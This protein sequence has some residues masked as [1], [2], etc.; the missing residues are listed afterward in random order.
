MAAVIIL[1]ALAGW[2]TARYQRARNDHTGAKAAVQTTRRI[3]GIE[4]RG[5]LLIAAIVFLAVWWW[6]DSH[7]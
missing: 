2:Y 1:A 3:L 7:S 6:L 4:R 5:F